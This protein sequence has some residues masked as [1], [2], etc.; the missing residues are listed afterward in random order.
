MTKWL[1]RR[2]RNRACIVSAL[3]L[4]AGCAN[5]RG[6]SSGSTAPA[7][8]RIAPEW[9]SERA[10]ETGL[11]FVHVN[12]ASGRFFYP[13][14]LG[15][16]VGL[17]D[18]DND[19]DLDVYLVQGRPLGI[20]APLDK[21]LKG[22]LFRNDLRINADGSRHL[23]FTD[24]T[25]A[26]GIQADQFGLGVAAADIDN[27]GW[28]D[29]LLTNFGTNQLFRN[30][31]NGT[32]TDVS[33]P[34]G[35]HDRSGR[36]A[37]SAAFL[38]YDRDGWLDLYVA[39]NVNYTLQNETS[40]PNMAG[41]RDYCPP[42]IYGGQ[43]DRLYR[44]QRNGRFADVSE[45]ALVGGTFGP[46]LGVATADYDGDGWIDIY[47]A[48]DGE[49]NLLWINQRN[50]TFRETALLAGAALTAE[51]IAEASMGV[52]AGDF[53][54]D[55]DEDL[56]MTELT[57][58]G[59]NLYANDGSGNF[60]DIS[61]LS[62]LG[63]LSMPYTGW[64]TAW[65][66]FD[67]DGWLDLLS[68]NGT[69]V[70]VDAA[71]AFPYHQRKVL[72]R[73]LRDGRFEDVTSQAGAVFKLSESGRGAAFGDIDNDGDVD[74]VVGNDGGRVRLLVNNLGNRNHWLGLRLVGRNMGRDM[75]GARV[76]VSR[77]GSTIWRRARADGSYGSANDPRVLVGLG[78]SAIPPAVK[79]RWPDGRLEEFSGVPI[80]RWTTLKE[81]T[82][83]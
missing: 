51:G 65:L 62:A 1:A 40:C 4:I 46:A 74:V 25:G 39:N 33:K 32:F 66:D 71:A 13:E 36:F 30:N 56:F 7:P 43:L 5:D 27:D 37:V 59:S 16:G 22:R 60:R 29:L 11:D 8:A 72:F 48:N 68:V 81:G 38:D 73:N 69:I 55:G 18:Y 47:V 17:L 35:V 53:D 63:K 52:D 10:E 70:A 77:D 26:S 24:V 42:Q 6:G 2:V 41:A 14:I 19:G 67:N 79:V 3:L 75:L 76:G 54:N 57:G 15:P 49:E 28:I 45:K 83:R 31:G 23:R 80:D 12:G 64:G 61:A 21:T 44:N 78:S 9:F 58:Q 82:G 34:S 20:G 50:G